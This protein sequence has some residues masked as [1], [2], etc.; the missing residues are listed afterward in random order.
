MTTEKKNTS[1]G[2]AKERLTKM[3]SSG[4]PRSEQK[5]STENIEAMGEPLAPS[6]TEPYEANTSDASPS[7]PVFFARPSDS[8]S[9]VPAVALSLEQWRKMEAN[10]VDL[11]DAMRV[12]DWERS[13]SLGE[14]LLSRFRKLGDLQTIQI[15]DEVPAQGPVGQ[16]VLPELH[17]FDEFGACPQTQR[18]ARPFLQFLAET[19]FR[20]RCYG[21]E[22]LPTTKPVILVANHSGVLPYDAVMLR[23]LV[24]EQS[25][26]GRSVR[27]LVEDLYYHAPFLGP[28]LYRLGCVRA[29]RDNA[30]RLLSRGEAVLVFPEGYKGLSKRFSQR[31]RLRRFGRGGFIKL[32]LRTGAPLLPVAVVGAEEMYPIL[33]KIH[34]VARA[35][36]LPFFPITPTFPLLG[37][38]G[39]AP[40]PSSWSIRF[41]QPIQ[42]PYGPDDSN[43]PV[44]INRLSEEFRQTLQSMLDLLVEERSVP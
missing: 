29:N 39:L 26:T 40:L 2:E 44:L 10:L 5:T 38:L 18:K 16:D 25:A 42:L 30:Q 23:H 1:Q 41:G 14:S 37:P 28:L 20:I 43:D 13:A 22:N 34:F 19:Y 4:A 31:Y 15:S 9:A 7:E 3:V 35:F 24:G 6:G 21:M 33:G 11:R 17:Q 12:S 8:Y 36:G 32:A 27:P